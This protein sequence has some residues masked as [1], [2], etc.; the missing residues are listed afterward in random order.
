MRAAESSFSEKVE[1]EEATRSGVLVWDALCLKGSCHIWVDGK[2]SDTASNAVEFTLYNSSTE[3]AN[4]VDGVVYCFIQDVSLSAV[5]TGTSPN[6]TTLSPA[7]DVKAGEMYK[8]TS[9]GGWSEYKG[10]VVAQ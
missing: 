8:Y 10:T 1:G 7:I 2:G 6:I 9:A 5:T 4:P 3:P